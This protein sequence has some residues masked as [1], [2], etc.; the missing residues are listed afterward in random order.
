M[1]GTC[2]YR[3]TSGYETGEGVWDK[4]AECFKCPADFLA[5]NLVDHTEPVMFLEPVDIQMKG[6]GTN[7]FIGIE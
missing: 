4:V 2:L 6:N 3:G 5:L 1:G 7:L